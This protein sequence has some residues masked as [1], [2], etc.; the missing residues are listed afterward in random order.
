MLSSLIWWRESLTTEED[1]RYVCT[2]MERLVKK[3]FSALLAIVSLA[4]A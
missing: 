3:Y 4:L 2:H 1:K